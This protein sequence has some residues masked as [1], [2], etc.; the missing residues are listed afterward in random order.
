MMRVIAKEVHEYRSEERAEWR[1][2][3]F[4]TCDDTVALKRGIALH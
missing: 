2:D 3:T 1:N 4:E